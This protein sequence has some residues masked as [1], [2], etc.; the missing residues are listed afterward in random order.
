MLVRYKY[1][2]SLKDI[3]FYILLINILKKEVYLAS[4]LLR[5][6]NSQELSTRRLF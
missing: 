5:L 4:I 2:S 1:H 6:D 3:K